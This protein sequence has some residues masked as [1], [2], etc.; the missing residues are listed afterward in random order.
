MSPVEF[1]C[2]LKT[3][4]EPLPHFWEHTVGSGHATLA[5]RSDWQKQ[6]TRCRRDLGFRHVRFHGLLSD[7]MGTLTNQN[8]KLIYSFFNIDQIMDFLLSIGMRPFLELS[9]MPEAL[10]SGHKTVFHYKANVTP[11]KDHDAWAEL[12][13]KLATHWI[14]RYGANEVE[15][16]FFE[17]WNEPNLK[18]FWTGS[19]QDYFKFYKTTAAALKKVD[20]KIK[21]GGPATAK[22]EWLPEFVKFCSRQEVPL[23]FVS[24]HHYPTDA[25][26]KPGDDTKAQLK[27]SHRS[28]LR[29]EAKKAKHEVGKKPLYYT[30]WAS[31]SNPFD[32]MHDEPYA[33]AFILKTVMEARPF[34]E[35][36]SYWTFSDIFEENYF[37]SQPFHGGFGLQTIYG[38]P[39]PS[40]RAYE[41]LHSLG[42]QI[43]KVSGSHATVDAWVIRGPSKVQVLVTNG[44][45]P[46]H[47]IRSEDV[48]L[49][50][51]NVGSFQTAYLER[52]DDAHANA[53]RKWIEMGSP[54]TLL[55]REVHTLEAA[56]S[57]KKQ[58]IQ[59]KSKKGLTIIDLTV[60]SQGSVLIT[61]ESK[62]E[63]T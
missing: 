7:D 16:W 46:G 2:D 42:D 25:F 41:L 13:K 54:S 10:A 47:P 60:P 30:E 4:S 28:V 55:P 18:A 33:A 39:K 36:Y 32:E 8:K 53:K 50:L 40:Y 57:L 59:L 22:N 45:L 24:T 3:A 44:S 61:L 19:K 17:I 38:T 56:S 31:S 52:I 49:Q 20:K 12:I 1:S 5:L 27:A 9:F 62:S 51:K 29:E 43:Y 15:K 14:R 63:R 48:R 21:V 26:G 23:D 34:V 11:P 37:S 6:L 35:G 58:V